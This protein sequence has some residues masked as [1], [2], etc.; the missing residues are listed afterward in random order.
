M[1]ILLVRHA[2]PDYS[3]DSLT[4]KGFREAEYLAERLARQQPSALYCSPL[5][6]AQR[7]AEP[8]AR[9]TGQP[10]RVLDWLTEFPGSI[11]DGRGG[12][13]IPWNLEPRF[14]TDKPEYF[15]I[16]RWLEEETMAGGT[17]P[18]SYR[19]VTAC[20]DDFLRGY[21]YERS[22]ILYRCAVNRD[23][24]VVLFCHFALGMVLT[25]HLSGISPVL[26]WQTLFLPTSSVTTFVTE[27][28]HPGEVVFKCLQMGDTSHLYAHDEPVSGSGLFPEFFD[29]KTDGSRTGPRR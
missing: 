22:G 19:H 10:V 14:W 9:R 1:R 21:G 20:L 7:T 17:V 15:D 24:T 18:A 3:R 13:T 27:E 5:G 28:R 4:E 23:E 16:R 11:P 12:L 26:L 6:R 2:E 29:R 8:T 25:S